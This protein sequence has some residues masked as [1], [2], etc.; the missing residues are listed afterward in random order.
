M[1]R[2]I[3]MDEKQAVVDFV[4]EMCKLA[5][6][7]ADKERARL[8]RELTELEVSLIAEMIRRQAKLALAIV[9]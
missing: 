4:G 9:R 1:F 8:G 6:S 2:V 7:Q 5:K 3:K